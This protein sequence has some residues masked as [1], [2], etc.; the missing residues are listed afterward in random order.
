MLVANAW[1][2]F[3]PF[4][5]SLSKMISVNS[6]G[7]LP[8][9]PEVRMCCETASVLPASNSLVAFLMPFVFVA[10]MRNCMFLDLSA[11]ITPVEK[12]SLP[13]VSTPIRMPFFVHPS[14]SF[15]TVSGRESSLLTSVAP[16][17]ALEPFTVQLMVARQLKWYVPFLNFEVIMLSM[18]Y[19]LSYLGM[20]C[21]SIATSRNLE[22]VVSSHHHYCTVSHP[23]AASQHIVIPD[24][25]YYAKHPLAARD[26]LALTLCILYEPRVVCSLC[27]LAVPAHV[28]ESGQKVVV[29]IQ[30]VVLV[31]ELKL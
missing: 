16:R 27:I 2:T 13:T 17:N 6:S 22:H 21:L 10:G 18:L 4:L 8:A 30:R 5:S 26:A 3:L 12:N 23:K 31:G 28:K 19:I 11:P 25:F 24:L 15:E 29:A 7:P 14:M 20:A 1:I 9:L